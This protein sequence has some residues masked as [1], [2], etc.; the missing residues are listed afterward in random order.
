MS[1]KKVYT[2]KELQEILGVC[3]P[4]IY[5][6]LKTEPFKYVKVGRKYLI[7]KESFDNWLNAGIDY[8]SPEELYNPL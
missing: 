2:V 1:E 4:T 8:S 5:E 3:R 6:L 7:S